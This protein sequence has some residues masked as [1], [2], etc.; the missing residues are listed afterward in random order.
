LYG[1]ETALREAERIC[2]YGGETAVRGTGRNGLYADGGLFA[3]AQ[4]LYLIA[5]ETIKEMDR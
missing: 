1:G 4:L 2:L 5:G 3:I